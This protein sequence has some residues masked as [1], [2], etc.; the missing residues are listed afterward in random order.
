LSLD[1][2]GFVVVGLFAVTW[3]GAIAFWR[4]GRPERRWLPLP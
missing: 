2:V 4:Y 1:S 3:A